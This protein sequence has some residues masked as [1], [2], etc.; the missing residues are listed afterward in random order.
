M[1]IL[2]ILLLL[3]AGIL[4]LLAEL[5]LIPGTS[6]AS[7]LSLGFF[8]YANYY[9]FTVL[10]TTAGVVTLCCSVVIGAA[11]LVWFMR[12]K[13]LDRVSLKTTLSGSVHRDEANR[14]HV[15][16]TGVTLTRLA[17]IGQARIGEY[18]VEVKSASGL[19]DEKTP[20][21]VTRIDGGTLWV[22]RLES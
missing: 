3:L 2:I 21:R 9:A 8:A 19:L 18:I 20:I 11:S 6:L 22:E 14:V 10:G 1:E 17:L 16:D 5:F 4:F 7:L 12:S 15:G 13:T